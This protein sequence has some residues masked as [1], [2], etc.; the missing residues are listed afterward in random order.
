MLVPHSAVQNVADR[1]VVYMSDAQ[2]LARFIEREVRLG[3]SSGDQV[4]VV[5]GLQQGDDVVTA[6]S[7]SGAAQ[8]HK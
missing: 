4:V 7:F 5:S 8:A 6:G 3:E 2:A 1:T